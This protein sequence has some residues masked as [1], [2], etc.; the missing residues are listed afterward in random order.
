M[1]AARGNR[2]SNERRF[3]MRWSAAQA[4]AWILRQRPLELSKW[5]PDMGPGLEGAQKELANEAIR[6][7]ELRAVKR[8]RRTLILPD[9]LRAWVESLPSVTARTSSNR[10]GV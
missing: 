3:G 10:E 4:L 5:T 8:G 6:S 1:A 7:G 2:V 9:D